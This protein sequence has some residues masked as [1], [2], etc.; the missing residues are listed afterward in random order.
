MKNSKFDDDGEILVV[1]GLKLILK[2]KQE[3]CTVVANLLQKPT[4]R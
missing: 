1:G 4:R 2:E 3:S